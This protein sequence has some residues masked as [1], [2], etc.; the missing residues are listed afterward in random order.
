[1]KVNPFARHKARRLVLQALYQWQ[2]SEE[3][4]I[5]IEEQFLVDNT[6]MKFDRDYFKELLHAIPAK[7][8]QIDNLMV[9]FL[10]RKIKELDPV[11]L[12]I[13]RIGCYELS[14]RLEIP[15]RVVI[16]EALELA[17]M[18][19]AEDGHKYVNGILDKLSRQLRVV[20][21][22]NFQDSKK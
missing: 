9:P 12:N 16:N 14:E 18:F 3:N 4:L 22:Q 15:Y 2:L 21:I 1:M 7:L 5:K 17:K 11:E 19:G 13:M 20:E 6:E 10:D 8:D